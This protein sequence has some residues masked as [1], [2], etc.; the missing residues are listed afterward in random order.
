MKKLLLL[1]CCLLMAVL[2]LPGAMASWEGTLSVGGKVTVVEPGRDTYDL[3]ISITG[4]GT[5]SPAAGTHRIEKGKTVYLSAYPA[6]GWVFEG[7]MIQGRSFELSS[8]IS[9]LMIGD[10]SFEAVFIEQDISGDHDE[11][12]PELEAGKETD[13]SE[14]EKGG[15][16]AEPG[17]GGDEDNKAGGA[18]NGDGEGTGTGNEGMQDRAE[19]EGDTGANGE[20]E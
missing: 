11:K 1:V 13:D 7:W 4:E 19:A 9:F 17:P 15:Q 18:E 3:T 20:E 2:L 6:E 12:T 16:E 14:V 5:T 8:E 10:I